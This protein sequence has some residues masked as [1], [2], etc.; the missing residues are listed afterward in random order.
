M[1]PRRTSTSDVPRTAAATAARRR[2]YVQQ[3]AEKLGWLIPEMTDGQLAALAGLIVE[4]L[5]IRNAGAESG[6]PLNTPSEVLGSSEGPAGGGEI[7]AWDT[8]ELR[9]AA[10]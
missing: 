7:P 3:Q 8:V 5:E 2:R 4:E 9:R 6:R 10:G 1:T